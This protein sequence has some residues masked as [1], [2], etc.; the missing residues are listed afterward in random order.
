MWSSYVYATNLFTHLLLYNPRLGQH[1]TTCHPAPHGRSEEEVFVPHV[2]VLQTVLLKGGGEVLG[3]LGDQL[4]VGVEVLGD[5]GEIAPP[6]GAGG[7]V[8]G[9]DGKLDV[10]D[11]GVGAQHVPRHVHFDKQQVLI[12]NLQNAKWDSFKYEIP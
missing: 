2:E 11:L 5:A 8:I 10:Q 7:K 3:L 6:G 4:L 9:L 1:E 12:Y